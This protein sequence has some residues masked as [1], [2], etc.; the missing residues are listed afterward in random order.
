MALIAVSNAIIEQTLFGYSPNHV[1]VDGVESS[2]DGITV[3]RISGED[4]PADAG[5][6]AA[7]LNVQENRAGQ[8]F[9]TMSFQKTD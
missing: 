5:E 7:T 9:I 3:F 6:V 2:G 1:T 8:R 4:V